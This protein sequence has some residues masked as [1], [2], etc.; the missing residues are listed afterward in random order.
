MLALVLALLVT[1]VVV[2]VA[3]LAIWSYPGKPAPLVSADGKPL[4][5]GVSEKIY[6]EIG[7]VEQG[8]FIVGKSAKNPVLLYLHGGMP[9]YVLTESHPTGLE[10]DF[11]VVWWE[12]RGVGI[13]YRSDVDPATLTADRYVADAVELT[14]YLRK[15]FGQDKIYVMA[16]SGGTF[17][18]I[19][20]VAKHPELFHAYVAVAQIADQRRSEKLAYDWMLAQYRAQGNDGMVAKLEAT[21]VTLEGGTPDDYAS[22]RDTAMHDLGVGTTHE[23]RSVVSGILLPSLRSPQYTMGEKVRT[24][25]GKASSG[26]STMW[27]EVMKT[28]L[29]KVVP[30]VAIPVYFLEGIHDYTCAYAVAKDY[31]AK[32]S[33]PV[34]GFY[35][36]DD[37][38]HSPI[39]EEPDKARKILREDVLRGRRDLADP[40]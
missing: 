6:V 3:T 13:S 2:L 28:D 34:K 9:D 11:T 16:H 19:Q 18:G 15:R 36:F 12:Q 37:S 10:D 39:F 8:M 17:F 33:A 38:A 27:K 21:P 30:E 20:L 40:Q 7:G 5:D 35:T 1:P 31:F 26:I 29:A 22:V 25:R 4:P 24:W 32:L 23:M 14:E